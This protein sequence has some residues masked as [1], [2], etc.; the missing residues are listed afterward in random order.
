MPAPVPDLPSAPAA[1]RNQEA[2]TAVLER[3]LAARGRVLEVASGTGQH[4]A[5]WARRFAALDWQPS[6]VD[7]TA[8]E[9][10]R[11]WRRHAGRSNL[12]APLRLDVS[13]PRWPEAAP[14]PWSAI[15]A[16]N[17]LHISPWPVTATL[18]EG[19]GHVLAPGGRLLVYGPFAEGGVLQ[20]ESNV[21]FD[22]WLKE[23]DGRW[24]VRDVD[25]VRRSAADVGLVL[26]EQ[27]AMPANNRVLVLERVEHAAGGSS[28]CG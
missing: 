6:D 13:D 20:P 11:A 22:A 28:A 7:E 9:G 4:V 16:V 17:L 14:G 19:A 1:A 10:I 25:D 26:K 24:G 27:V 12:A 3:L 21:A 2:L 8:L 23:R 5:H 15:V 18:L